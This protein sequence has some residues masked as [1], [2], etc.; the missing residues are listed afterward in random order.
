MM[1]QV[2][3]NGLIIG[4]QYALIG[5][6]FAI[7]YGVTRF[8]HFAHGAVYTI[9]AYILYVCAGMIHM[10]LILAML[11]AC[12]GS[13]IAGVLIDRICYKALRRNGTTTKGFLLASLG[14]YVFM[15]NSI[16]LV[17]GDDTK[18]VRGYQIVEGIDLLGAKVTPVQFIILGVSLLFLTMTTWLL[19]RTR[20]GRDIR[21]VANNSELAGAS[22]IDVDRI[23]IFTFALGSLLAGVA[24]VLVSLDTD[25]YPVMGFN[26]L[27]MSV[28]AVVIGGGGNLIGAVLGGLLIGIVQHVGVYY[29]G[30]QWQDVFAF[31]VLIA[32]LIFRPH[33]LF[34][35]NLRKASI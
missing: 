6:G 8:F 10:P 9:G 11:V 19:Y 1:L 15:Q 4:S 13:A 30:S 18:T 34:G 3:L 23:Y 27:L 31:S 25:I 28:V 20:I 26:A 5:L 32:F 29:F 7:I 22:G 17:F 35:E 24:A 21:A 33:G 16:S 14:I 2:L 12:V